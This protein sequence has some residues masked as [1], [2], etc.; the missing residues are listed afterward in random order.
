[1][2]VFVFNVHVALLQV[3]Q[4]NKIVEVLGMPPKHLLDQAH[5]T[6]KYFDKLPD[7]SYLMKKSKDG[8]KYRS[9]AT[10]RLHDILGVEA[11]GPS[12]RRIGEPGHAVAD[13]L[14]FKVPFVLPFRIRVP[15]NGRPRPSIGSPGRSPNLPATVRIIR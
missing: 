1:M 15:S 5:K 14:K 9:P 7:G 11:G 3:D 4:M 13:Y 2:S 10:R 8:K 12:G 6:R